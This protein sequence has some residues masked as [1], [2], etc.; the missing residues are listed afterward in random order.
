MEI[1]VPEHKEHTVKNGIPEVR[2]R[3][4]NSNKITV[5]NFL[6]LIE[7]FESDTRKGLLKIVFLCIKD[8][9]F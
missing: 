8:Y 2:R 7:I 4:F 5:W 9:H 6:E 1:G 3:Y